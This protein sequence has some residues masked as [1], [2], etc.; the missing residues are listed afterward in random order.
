MCHLLEVVP[1][2]RD[3]LLQRQLILEFSGP[4]T[5][6]QLA[7]QQGPSDTFLH[8]KA[9]FGVKNSE[10]VIKGYLLGGSWGKEKNMETVL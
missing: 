8:L 4:V 10:T 1:R 9:I 2:E 5:L 7:A 3:P 6:A